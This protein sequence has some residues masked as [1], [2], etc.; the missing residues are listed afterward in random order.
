M[1]KWKPTVD[2]SVA[3]FVK[4]TSFLYK[5]GLMD[6]AVAHLKK[7]KLAKIR[8]SHAHIV[9]VQEMLKGHFRENMTD[10][11]KQICFSIHQIM[12][13]PPGGKDLG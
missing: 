4:F 2:T 1:D 8:I 10:E 11:C 9:A 7:K 5:E 3:R 12:P 6:K 13:P